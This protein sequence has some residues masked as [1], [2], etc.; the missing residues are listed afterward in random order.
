MNKFCIQISLFLLS[1]FAYANNETFA[2]ET[3][4]GEDTKPQLRSRYPTPEEVYEKNKHLLRAFASRSTVPELMKKAVE[5][6]EYYATSKDGYEVYRQSPNDSIS[7]Y[8][9]KIDGE[10][11]ILKVHLNIYASSQYNDIVNRLWDPNSPNIFNKGNVKVSRVYNPNLI[12]ICQYYPKGSKSYQKYFTAFVSKA[13]ISKDK[14][15]IA[16]TSSNSTDG[17]HP[18]IKYKNPVLKNAYLIS[19]STI[20]KDYDI[21]EKSK[22][23]HVNLAGY[24]IEKKGDDLEITYI[25]S[26]DGHSSI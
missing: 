3:A 21:N 14:T 15:I 23:V 26:I 10:A 11:S 8:V 5:Q 9:K 16:M 25:E 7:Y 4:P 17:N 20:P 22:I 24:L 18:D 2:A 1:I 6:I 12:G 13:E 19:E